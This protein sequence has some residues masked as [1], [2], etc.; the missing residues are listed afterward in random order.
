MIE[1]FR[2]NKNLSFTLL[3]STL[4]FLRK[5]IQ[6][7]AIGSYIPLL[8][9]IS[10]IVL[11]AISVQKRKS[12]FCFIVKIWATI[13]II[14]SVIR[15][16]I[17]IIHITIKPFDGSFHLAQQFNGYNLIVSVL[18]LVVGIYMF[19]SLNKKRI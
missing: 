6:Y 4:F 14:W 10:L 17:S 2:A 1:F 9:I 7:L 3:V 11:L 15:L 19:R 13:L 5:G 18:M 16:L 12:F 8:I